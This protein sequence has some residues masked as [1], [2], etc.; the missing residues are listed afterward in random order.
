MLNLI[1]ST[2][3]VFLLISRHGKPYSPESR[4]P[5][6]RARVVRSFKSPT[7]LRSDGFT[8]RRH[9][10]DAGGAEPEV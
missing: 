3:V 6:P 10:H 8:C 5:S 2:V 9:L 7:K 1:S 4:Q